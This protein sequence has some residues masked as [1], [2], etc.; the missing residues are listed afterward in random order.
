MPSSGVGTQFLVYSR[1]TGCPNGKPDA[2]S[3]GIQCSPADCLQ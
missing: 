3:G 2:R 1:I